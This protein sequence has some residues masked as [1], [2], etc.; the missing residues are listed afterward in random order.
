M[1]KDHN[2]LALETHHLSVFRWLSADPIWAH[3]HH[4]TDQILLLHEMRNENDE[5]IKNI[6]LHAINANVL[7]RKIK[8]KYT[9]L[10][11]KLKN[12]VAQPHS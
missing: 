1:V 11:T 4:V 5:K 6:V 8:L 10:H 7:H 12:Y 2:V 9:T 3:G